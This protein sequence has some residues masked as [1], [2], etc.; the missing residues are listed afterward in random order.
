MAVPQWVK[1]AVF[2]QIFPDR[3]ANGDPSNDPPNVQ[4]WGTVPTRR[5]FQGGDLKGIANQMDYL[6]D[7]GINAIYFN[8]IFMAAST[9]RY[10]T[11]DYLQ[12]DPKLGN[13]ADFHHL[14]NTCHQNG[15]RVILDGVFNHCARG[16]FAFNDILENGADSPYLNWF[17]VKKFPLKA[18]EKGDATNYKAWW[19]IKACRSLI[20]ITLPYAST[21]STQLDIGST[22]ARMVGAW[23]CPMR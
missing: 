8:P 20:Q 11:I 23:M 10:D 2:Y 22:R 21:S 1:D 17:H 15:V 14:V 13:L 18:Y 16:F 5:G 19:G 12:I 6:L 9:H 7:L 4:P 3:F